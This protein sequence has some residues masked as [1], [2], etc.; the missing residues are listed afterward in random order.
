MIKLYES[1]KTIIEHHEEEN[2]VYKTY[3][4]Q[5]IF[6]KEWLDNYRYICEKIPGLVHVHELLNSGTVNKDK[7]STIVMEYV[8]VDVTADQLLTDRIYNKETKK[9]ELVNKDKLHPTSLLAVQIKLA[10][11][12]LQSLIYNKHLRDINAG[13]Y[14]LP[15]DL[16]LHNMVLTKEGNLMFLDPDQ[17]MIHRELIGYGDYAFEET[18]FKMTNIQLRLFYDLGWDKDWSEK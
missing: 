1:Q 11:T 10:E 6:S 3:K 14:F 15:G 13:Y 16:S 18:I 17:W 12:K 5:A 2:K 8:D 7:F 4:P 9:I